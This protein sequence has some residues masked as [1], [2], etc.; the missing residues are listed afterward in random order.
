MAREV[1]WL[2]EPPPAQRQVPAA[3]PPP[4]SRGREAKPGSLLWTVR[5]GQEGTSGAL[6][7]LHEEF[8]LDARLFLE[9]GP[10]L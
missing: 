8:V 9:A 4:P 3:G 10:N 2:L 7:S 1:K 5:D 6:T